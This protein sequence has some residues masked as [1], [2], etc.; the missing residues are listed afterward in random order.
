MR[1]VANVSFA[2]H[3]QPWSQPARPWN[4]PGRYYPGSA[5]VDWV[6][7]SVYGADAPTYDWTPFPVGLARAIAKLTAI[8]PGKPIAVL[9]WGGVEAPARGD[10]TR[11]IER[12][13]ASLAERRSAAVRGISWWDE[14][15]ENDDGSRSDLRID[16]SPDA[17][18]AYRRGIA[19]S[20]YESAPRFTCIADG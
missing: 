8:A 11:W 18:A 13:F 20:R 7:A 12:A 2:F 15:W 1:G 17:L 16:S 10:K 6:G 4:D 9:E 19:G 14:R 3:I 5:Y